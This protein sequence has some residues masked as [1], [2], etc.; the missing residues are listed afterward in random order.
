[1]RVEQNENVPAEPDTPAMADALKQAARKALR[2]A[3]AQAMTSTYV[4]NRVWDA[5]SY[6]TMSESDFMPASECDELLDELVTAA[7]AHPEPEAA[8]VPQGLVPGWNWLIHPDWNDGEPT[9]AWVEVDGGYFWY[10]PVDIQKLPQFAWEDRDD[11]WEVAATP[12]PP[13]QPEP[14]DRHVRDSGFEGWFSTYK[15]EGKTLKQRLREAYATGMSD[16]PAQPEPQQSDWTI[17]TTKP[18][19]MSDAVALLCAGKRPSDDLVQGWLA[20]TDDGLQEFAAT[21]GPAWAQGIGL[22]DAAAVMVDQPTEGVEHEGL[23]PAQ[24]QEPVNRRLLDSLVELEDVLGRMNESG[25]CGHITRLKRARAAIAE[26]EAQPAPGGDDLAALCEQIAGH[27]GTAWIVIGPDGSRFLAESP[28]RAANEA[29]KHRGR[30]LFDPEKAKELQGV[31]HK[32]RADAD[33]ENDRLM[34]MYGSLNCPICGG[35]GHIGDAESSQP[36]SREG[37]SQAAQDVL[38]E[39]LRQ[40]E[41]EGYTLEH[42]DAHNDRELAE[43]AG[44]YALWGS[45]YPE[46]GR[47]P[48]AWPWD[49]HYWNPKKPRE[50]YVRA[51]ALLLAAVEHKD[52][53][54]AHGIGSGSEDAS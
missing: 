41:A 47:C 51:A 44:C 35:S 5:W 40:I 32:L 16:Q 4:C 10:M 48:G 19:R 49:A 2:N 11:A 43:A 13:A 3:L 28:L 45:A 53:A 54:S 20:G 30:M 36:M 26:A 52:R 24:P 34:A 31:I 42:D 9:P 25:E 15:L 29:N 17:P 38:A 21:H 27:L 1:M 50:N 22:L 7:L 23:P 6:G 14:H 46:K 8:Q 12:L 39:R 37:M 18:Q 33:A